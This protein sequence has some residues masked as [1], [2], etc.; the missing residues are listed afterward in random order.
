[1]TVVGRRAA[2]VMLA[3]STIV[4]TGACSHKKHAAPARAT[5][6]VPG[7]ITLAVGAAPGT[8]APVK[9]AVELVLRRYV[10]DAILTPLRTG[11]PVADVA[12]FF[13]AEA[14]ARLTGPD[15]AALVGEGLPAAR[16]GLVGKRAI[17]AITPMLVGDQVPLVAVG[18]D[19]RVV[20]RGVEGGDADVS[21]LGEL[22]MVPDGATWRV[23]GYDMRATRDAGAPMTTTTAVKR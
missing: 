1:V 6:T 13:T 22:V 2:T 23:D 3:L 8:P 21:Y 5:T 11:Q 7:P 12:P 15:R 9:D 17:A 18:L 19:L 14:V 4:A 10:D 20:A 16:N